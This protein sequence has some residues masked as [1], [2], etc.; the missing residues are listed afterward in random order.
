MPAPWGQAIPACGVDLIGYFAPHEGSATTA[1][2]VYTVDS[3]AAYEAYRE[4]LS[5]HPLGRENYEFSKREKFI[6]NEDRKD[7]NNAIVARLRDEFKVL[8]VRR[9]GVANGQCIRVSPA[10]YTT[11]TELDRRGADD[12]R[13]FL[14]T[15]GVTG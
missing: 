3:L 13:R 15:T 9:A 2:G 1:Y 5:A 6:L 8:T 4:R 7:D 10:L 12:S 14:R 11:E